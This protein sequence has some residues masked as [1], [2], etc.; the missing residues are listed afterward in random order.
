MR[1]QGIASY[2]IGNGQTQEKLNRIIEY[3][4]SD[5]GMG[6]FVPA[7]FCRALG[8]EQ[9][10]PDSIGGKVFPK[11]LTKARLLFGGDPV[12]P[13][14]QEK[15]PVVPPSNCA[16]AI[17]DYEYEGDI[18]EFDIEGFHFTFLGSFCSAGSEM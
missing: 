2:W 15:W 8:I 6:D 12:P 1:N 18:T 16:V 11:Q 9:Y 4:I 17:F 5:G 3:T 10:E 13:E 7:P 14:L